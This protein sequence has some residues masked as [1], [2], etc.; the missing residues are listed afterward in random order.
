[1]RRTNT[2]TKR[3]HRGPHSARGIAAVEFVIAV[4]ILIFLMLALVEVGGA[5]VAYDALTY[6]VRHGARYVSEHAIDGTSGNVNLTEEVIGEAQALTVG[7]LVSKYGKIFSDFNSE[8]VTV[9]QV[10]E[11]NIRVTATYPYHGML[12]QALPS[13][14]TGRSP[15]DT[16]LITFNVAVTMR[17]IY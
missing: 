14:G 12:R 13:Y 17:A 15:I 8:Q 16:S 2:T 3:G 10:G 4:P 6:S 11:N 5:L 9:E 7:A 1:M